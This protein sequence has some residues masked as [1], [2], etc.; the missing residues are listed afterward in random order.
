MTNEEIE[1]SLLEALRVFYPDLPDPEEFYATRW[2]EDPW[3]KG[4]YSYYAVGNE[5]NITEYIAEPADRFLFAG[6]AASDKPGT[7]LGAYLSGKREA[8]RISKLL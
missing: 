1:E 2:Y 3:S 6:E 5:R 7:V 4:S 8:E